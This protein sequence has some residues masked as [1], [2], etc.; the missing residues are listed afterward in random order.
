MYAQCSGDNAMY[1]EACNAF[2]SDGNNALHVACQNAVSAPT[3]SKLISMGMSINAPNQKGMTPMQLAVESK[4]PA[5]IMELVRLGADI[6]QV[7]E[8]GD[9]I[10]MDAVAV[11]STEACDAIMA[12]ASTQFKGDTNQIS[13][14]VQHKNKKGQNALVKAVEC[15]HGGGAMID[16]LSGMGFD[17]NA[18]DES[19][20]TI[21]H[22]AS[23]AD[24]DEVLEAI[25]AY[26]TLQGSSSA[27][28][29][30]CNTLGETP[31]HVAAKKDNGAAMEKLIA[32][33]A[34]IHQRNDKTG[35][36]VQETAKESGATHAK[37]IVTNVKLSAAGAGLGEL[38]IGLSWCDYNDLDLSVMSPLG[39]RIYYQNRRGK[40]GGI[41][42]I[43]QNFE[44]TE[45][46]PVEHLF[47]KQN[48]PEGEYKVFSVFFNC[49]E[50]TIRNDKE[51]KKIG[52]ARP[53]PFDVVIKHLKPDL[54]TV[55][56]IHSCAG[57]IEFD[58]KDNGVQPALQQETML[59]TK[60]AKNVS[61]PA[62]VCACI[63]SYTRAGGIS[64]LRS[65]SQRCVIEEDTYM[66]RKAGEAA[67]DA[68]VPP[69]PP[70]MTAKAPSGRA[71]VPQSSGPGVPPPPPPPPGGGPGK[72]KKKKKGGD[73]DIAAQQA[74]MMENQADLYGS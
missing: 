13:G 31:L 68:S 57:S 18:A 38:Q 49:H 27:A 60:K 15:K 23:E 41:L 51:K 47:W 62:Y 71:A 66:E 40:C 3:I 67:R 58:Q 46:D 29:N 26:H 55:V 11:G 37:D 72:K 6:T 10:F 39:E 70:P 52:C 30:T 19:G 42:D 54:S 50:Y 2:N 4:N 44:P 59:K 25:S 45:P 22:M 33:G 20:N 35:K 73:N 34:N 56:S 5:A 24:N 28:F 36:S 65:G 14:Y 7:D 21:V 61:D 43:D 63:F 17:M 74:A 16:K 12:A 8:D 1:G 32:R 64:N 69:P 9:T 53:C 48:P